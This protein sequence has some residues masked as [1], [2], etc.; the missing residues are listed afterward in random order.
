VGDVGVDGGD[1]WIRSVEER[2]CSIEKGFGRGMDLV[3]LS[4]RVELR[5]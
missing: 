4:W 5:D 3:A 2:R 1:V